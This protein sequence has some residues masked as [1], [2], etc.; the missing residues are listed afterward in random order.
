MDQPKIR[1]IETLGTAAFDAEYRRAFSGELKLP[2][3]GNHTPALPGTM[4]W[5]C[6]QYYASAV[7]KALG[8]STRKVRCGILDSVC[9]RAGRYQYAMMERSTSRNYGTRRRPFPERPTPVSKRCG[10]SSRGLASPNIATPPRTR[11]AT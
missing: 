11:H 2:L 4:R 3:T 10:N 8:S 7:F 9:R 6:E 1:L 5:L